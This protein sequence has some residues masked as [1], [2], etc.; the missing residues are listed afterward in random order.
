MGD[1]E[2]EIESIMLYL[3][4]DNGDGKVWKYDF[5]SVTDQIITMNDEPIR[6]VQGMSIEIFA[7]KNPVIKIEQVALGNVNEKENN[8]EWTIPTIKFKKIEERIEV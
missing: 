1:V 2:V 5:N 6:G 4:F 8:K 7:F 3:E